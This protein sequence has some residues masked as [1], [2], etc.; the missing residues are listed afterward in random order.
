MERRLLV[1]PKSGADARSTSGF[2]GA[3]LERRES[4]LGVRLT[5]R[6]G[7]EERSRKPASPLKTIPADPL[8]GTAD[9][10]PADPAAALTVPLIDD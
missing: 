4:K 7:A 6:R 2:D 1:P 3:V 5:T 9:A 8:P 10:D